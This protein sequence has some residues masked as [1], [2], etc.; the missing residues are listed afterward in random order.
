MNDI[1]TGQLPPPSLAQLALRW[2]NSNKKS[3]KEADWTPLYAQLTAFLLNDVDISQLL[4]SPEVLH[5]SAQLLLNSLV[6]LYFS[7]NADKSRRTRSSWSV[8]G[9]RC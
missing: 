6:C 4:V 3:R 2:V 9:S 8:W 1:T 7:L 5:E